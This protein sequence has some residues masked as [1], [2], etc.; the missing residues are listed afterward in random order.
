MNK[1]KMVLTLVIICSLSGLVLS[2]VYN[3]TQPIIIANKER[4]L[5]QTLKEVLPLAEEFEKMDS[6][7]FQIYKGLKNNNTIGF[8]ILTEAKGFQS[9]IKILVG[10]VNDTIT[11]VKIIEQFETPGLGARIEEEGFLNQ[12]ESKRLTQLDVDAI[13][14]ATISSEAVINA[15]KHIP[16]QLR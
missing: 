14:G 3:Y 15:I 12:F 6:E 7:H 16:I 9:T 1:I 8:A 2:L 5:N 11:K 4:A 13:T 10:I